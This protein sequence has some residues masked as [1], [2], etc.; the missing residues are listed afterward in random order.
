MPPQLVGPGK[1]HHEQDGMVYMGKW[2]AGC[3][4]L[5]TGT[6]GMLQPGGGSDGDV[7]GEVAPLPQ[8]C[9]PM[10]SHLLWG[11]LQQILGLS[12]PQ[13]AVTDLPDGEREPSRPMIQILHSLWNFTQMYGRTSRQVK[14]I[15]GKMALVWPLAGI[16]I[17][18]SSL[19]HGLGLLDWN[20]VLE[21]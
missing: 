4:Q 18:I 16:F 12:S 8:G 5:F 19:S 15:K 7:G 13:Q 14:R 6:K 1:S 20:Q 10:G 17:S 2:G 21:G 3:E 9:C 11:A